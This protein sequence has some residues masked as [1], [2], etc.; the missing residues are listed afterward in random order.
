MEGGCLS[1][2]CTP[3]LLEHVSDAAPATLHRHAA[4]RFAVAAVTVLYWMAALEAT[5]TVAA[6]PM[7]GPR[8]SK[9]G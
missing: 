6:R 9:L 4:A 2:P 8:R 5:G 7:G 1:R 3:D